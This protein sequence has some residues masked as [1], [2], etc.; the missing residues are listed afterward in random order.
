MRN[1]FPGPQAHMF[2]CR[3]QLRVHGG[4]LVFL[5]PWQTRMEL[6]LTETR[7]LSVGQ[8]QLWTTPWVMKYG[9]VNF[10][11][12]TFG[13]GPGSRIVHLTP[14]PPEGASTT[15]INAEVARRFD[16]IRATTAALT[17][18]TPSS[19]EPA[20]VS[21]SAQEGW[22]RRALPLLLA[23]GVSDALLVWRSPAL[24]QRG[25]DVVFVLACVGM[26]LF[27]IASAW[28]ALGFLQANRALRRG[29]LDV[30]T[31][32]EPPSARHVPNDRPPAGPPS[33][34]R[35]S[36]MAIGSALCAIPS[37]LLV[38]GALGQL[39]DSLGADGLPPPGFPRPPERRWCS[40]QGASW[41]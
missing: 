5:S 10:R 25:P 29:D 13:S 6:P 2:Q 8:F 15:T 1:S 23:F 26:L 17:G 37:W 3:G 27:G 38:L 4:D 12:L 30:V 36:W 14:I 33:P 39:H 22:N 24:A 16:V 32:D 7:D 40:E 28:Y 31:S 11:S 9:R 20:A 41:V 35:L 21:V 19:S 34:V 18:K